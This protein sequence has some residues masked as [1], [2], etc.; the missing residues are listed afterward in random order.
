MVNLDGEEVLAHLTMA[1]GLYPSKLYGVGENFE[2]MKIRYVGDF[3]L[4]RDA[5]GAR[6]R[7]D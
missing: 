7:R 6:P 1:M 4:Q 5:T 2:D 3:N